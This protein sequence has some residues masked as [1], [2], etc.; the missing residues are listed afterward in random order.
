MTMTAPLNSDLSS[1]WLIPGIYISLDLRGSSAGIGS[2]AK[3]ILLVGHKTSA[4]VAPLN[5]V[6]QLQ[7]QSRANLK[8]GR[9][10]DLSRLHAAVLA[11]IGGG[12]AD[13]YGV[14]VPEPA[15]GVASTHLL[16]FVG[17][18]KAAGVVDVT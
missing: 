6:V 14:A 9:G 10:S 3:R 8:F 12:A 1:N 4:G 13:I 5:T 2:L 7:G 17:D 15:G 16:I 18:S 11:Q